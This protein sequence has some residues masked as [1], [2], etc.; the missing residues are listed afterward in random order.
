MK[1]TAESASVDS[2][3]CAGDGVP[4]KL[5]E[6]II[7]YSVTIKYLLVPGTTATC[8]RIEGWTISVLKDYSV[9]SE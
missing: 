4:L 1:V 8:G 2:V 5:H 9:S 7:S 6:F 3:C